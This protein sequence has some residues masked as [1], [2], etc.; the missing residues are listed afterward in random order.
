MNS[1]EVCAGGGGQ[2]LGLEYAG[3]NH[4]A[5]VDI[6]HW[7]CETLK[8]NRPSWNVLQEDLRKFDATPFRGVDLLAGGV[9]C[10]PFSKAGK[11]LGADDDR[12]LFP[13]IIRLV[14]QC[15]PKAVLIE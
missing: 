8:N 13:E 4:V 10:P 2:A 9:P 7:S 5:L 6:D 3:F 12:N 14:R 15:E 1:L 11:Q